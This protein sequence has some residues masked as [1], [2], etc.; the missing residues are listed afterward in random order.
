MIRAAIVGIGLW[1]RNLVASVQGKSEAIHFVAGATR[2]PAKAAD[3]CKQHGIELVDN[4]ESVL[5]N[6]DIDAVV[7]TT[8]HSAHCEQIVAA[9]KAGKHIFVKEPI[10]VDAASSAHAVESCQ[11]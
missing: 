2:T 7:L 3:F 10:G 9:A 1:G 11:K 8:P 6:K 5:K 4:Y